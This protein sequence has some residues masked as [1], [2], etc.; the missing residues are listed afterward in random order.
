MTRHYLAYHTPTRMGYGG[1][2]VDVHVLKTSKAA[3]AQ[4]AVRDRATVWLIGREEG[5]L[6]VFWFGWLTAFR[7]KAPHFDARG[8]NGELHGD[9]T[10]YM[11]PMD[12]GEPVALTGKPWL[13]E[14]LNTLGNGA[15]GLQALH[16]P[17]IIAGL[18]Q[19]RRATPRLVAGRPR[20][21][22]KRESK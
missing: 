5:N 11:M 19:L 9:D 7:W 22:R 12:G 17:E 14:A 15:F 3:E 13:K 10:S 8:F 2:R 18:E 16:D 20:A 21:R 4:A 6:E 1:S